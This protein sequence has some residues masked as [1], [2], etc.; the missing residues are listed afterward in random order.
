MDSYLKVTKDIPSPSH[1]NLKDSFDQEDNRKRGKFNKLNKDLIKYT[2][3]E[4]I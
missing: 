4:R 3:I 1:Y 2:Y